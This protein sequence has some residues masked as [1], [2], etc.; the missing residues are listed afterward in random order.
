MLT[1]WLT[2]AECRQEQ[3]AIMMF[4]IVNRLVDIPSNSYLSS[5]P[6]I[7]AITRDL[8]NQWQELILT[9]IHFSHQQTKFA[10]ILY[11]SK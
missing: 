11:S 10:G 5:V 2:L 1:N 9:C 4:K 6:M 3:K 8:H 7:H